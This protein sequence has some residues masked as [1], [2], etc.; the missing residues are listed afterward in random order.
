MVIQA[1]I[2]LP[3]PGIEPTSSVFLGECVTHYATVVTLQREAKLHINE[4]FS[5]RL[6]FINIVPFLHNIT[7]Y[8][9]GLG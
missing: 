9:G 1:T 2:Y 5:I 7:Q 3:V 6:L 4:E 8:M